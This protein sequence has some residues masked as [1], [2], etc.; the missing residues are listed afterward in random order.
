MDI[1]G[2]IYNSKK[3]FIVDNYKVADKAHNIYLHIFASSGIFALIGYIGFV[4]TNI[5]NSLK[6]KNSLV[7]AICFASIAYSIQGIFNINVSE[8][9]SYFYILLGFMMSLLSNETIKNNK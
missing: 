8:V 5:I 3:E 4:I 7:I 6:S 1:L 9:T 2:R